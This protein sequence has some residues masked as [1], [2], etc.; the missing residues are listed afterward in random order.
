M[1]RAVSFVR[2]VRVLR[3]AGLATLAGLGATSLLGCQHGEVYTVLV[4]PGAEHDE[5]IVDKLDGRWFQ[6]NIYRPGSSAD[7]DAVELVYCPIMKG[8]STVCRTAVVWRRGVN[9]M[10]EGENVVA[11]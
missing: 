10:I 6:R 8:Q 7:L 1:K 11:R 3:L 9:V 4:P 5:V 2:L